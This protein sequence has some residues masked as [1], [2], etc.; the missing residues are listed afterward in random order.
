MIETLAL[1]PW[2]DSVAHE[3]FAATFV[4]AYLAG[5]IPFGLIFAR[6]AGAG[7]IRKVGSGNIGATNVLR[8]GK[9]WAAAATL[10]CDIAKGY[11][12]VSYAGE[13]L[14]IQFFPALAAL[15]VFIGHLYPLWL[16]FKGGKGVAVFI[17]ILI[18]I[19]PPIAALVCVSWVGT[20]QTFRYFLP[21]GP[22]LHGADAALFSGSGRDAVRASDVSFW[23]SSSSFRIAPISRASSEARNRGSER[24]MNALAGTNLRD[25]ERRAWLRLARTETIGPATFAA[26]IARFSDAREE[27]LAG[28]PA[29]GPARRQERA[30]PERGRRRARKSSAHHR[31]GGRLIACIEPDYP[32]GLAALDPP[33]PLICVLGNVAL[34]RRNMVAIVGARNASGLGIKFATRMA[35]DLGAAGLVVASGLGARHRSRR[36]QSCA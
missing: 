34:L 21:G 19:A 23:W 26:L 35:A 2:D 16:G 36:T 30:H 33:P 1:V 17:G 8:T 28:R 20:A 10:V 11:L 5:S 14:G 3:H 31:I 7:D 29:A 32:S 12:A 18:A 9:R 25:D 22:G 13:K 24:P 6:L 27:A 4:L 15:C